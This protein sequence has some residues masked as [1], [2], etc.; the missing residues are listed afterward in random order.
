MAKKVEIKMDK[1]SQEKVWIAYGLALN[2]G[3][4]IVIPIL[5]FGIGGVFLDKYLNTFPIFIFVGFV[6]AVTA[7]MLIVYVKMKDIITAGVAKKFKV[8]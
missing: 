2:L 5:V 6:L 3:Y 7:S 1:K 8:K 4:M